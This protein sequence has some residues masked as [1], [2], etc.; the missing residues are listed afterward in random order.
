MKRSGAKPITRETLE[1]VA[2]R[3]LD[4]FDASVAKLRRVLE[5]H[6]RRASRVHETDATAASQM[7]DELLARYVA[8]GL[9]SDRRFAE[10]LVVG[11]RARG[12]SQRRITHKLRERGI[13]QQ[14][15]EQALQSSGADSQDAEFRAA[16][17]FVRKKK[18]GPHRDPEQRAAR[19]KADLAALARAGFSYELARRVLGP[20]PD[21]DAF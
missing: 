13:G 17:E 16:V 6:V 7:I 9:L 5:G 3:Y 21:E 8:S 20:S 18:L 11:L 12:A 1:H 19:R 14:D 15:T 2:L 10:N 4:R